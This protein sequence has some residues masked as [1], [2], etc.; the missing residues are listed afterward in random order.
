MSFNS[1]DAQNARKK[2]LDNRK[3]KKQKNEEKIKTARSNKERKQ[4]YRNAN[5]SP[6]IPSSKPGHLNDQGCARLNI[7]YEICQINDDSRKVS[8]YNKYTNLKI[9]CIGLF[10][11]SAASFAY[12]RNFFPLPNER[13]VRRWISETNLE[14]T[15]NQ[16]LLSEA[17]NIIEKYIKEN[18]IN[19]IENFKVILSVDAFSMKP[20]LVIDDDGVRRGTIKDE[21]VDDELIKHMK[22]SVLEFEKYSLENK[23]IVITNTFVYLVQPLLSIYPCFIVHLSGSTQGKATINEI[24][25]LT[26]LMDVMKK[27][28]IQVEALSFDG[29]TTYSKL[30]RK[31]NNIV[32][33]EYQNSNSKKI[34]S[35]TIQKFSPKIAVDPLH[36]LKRWRY[37]LFKCQLQQFLIE[38]QSIVNIQQWKYD[39][40]IPSLALMDKPFLK[41]NDDLPLKLFDPQN[42]IKLH[43]VNDKPTFSYFFIPS[44]TILCLKYKEIS[45]DDRKFLLEIV[46]NYIFLYQNT[47]EQTKKP[48]TEH[49]Y[50]NKKMIRMFS[51]GIL[52]DTISAVSTILYLLSKEECQYI[53]LN[54]IGSNPVEHSIGKIR[55]LSKNENTFNKLKKIIG[56]ENLLHDIKKTLKINQKISGR[57]PTLGEDLQNVQKE[58]VFNLDPEKISYSMFIYLGFS[59]DEKTFKNLIKKKHVTSAKKC[60]ECFE[61]FISILKSIV[62]KE[63]R[64]HPKKNY[65]STSQFDHVETVKIQDRYAGKGNFFSQKKNE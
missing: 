12:L 33:K 42:L 15:P 29:D 32:R 60:Q 25:T 26:F 35:E 43:E 1:D 2:Q 28:K 52:E 16:F 22:E 23:K 14:T 5:T 54:R 3:T 53:Y 37:R 55:M 64:L 57:I 10:L 61:E 11:I 31:W 51:T 65:L 17:K 4:K 39:F 50:K 47:L 46:L 8:N 30:T 24:E 38:T 36:I 13:T 20:N 48:L 45:I 19:D 7:I 27:L 21:I 40:D 9:F 41:M 62:E 6:I 58:N 56:K 18:Q 44:I 49:S 63:S 34:K 59:N